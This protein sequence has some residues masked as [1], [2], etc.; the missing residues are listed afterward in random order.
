MPIEICKKR[1]ALLRDAGSLLVTGGAGAGKTTIALAKA[2]TDLDEGTLGQSGKA[3]FLSFARATIARV[4]EQVVKQFPKHRAR[5]EINTY[6]GFAWSILKSH[7]YLL[8][9]RR[10]VALLVPAMARRYLAG[11]SGE[12]R[13]RRLLDLFE[14]EGLVAFDLFMPLA[15]QIFERCPSLAEAYA[16]A[17]PLVV[18]DEFQDTSASEWALIKNLGRHSRMIA[19]GDPKQRIYDFKGADPKRFDDFV[20][21]FHPTVYDFEAENRRSSGT[22]IAAFGGDL[23]SGAFGKAEYQGVAVHRFGGKDGRHPLKEAVL[24]ADERLR[25]VGG[26][27]SL[28]VL[29]PTNALAA[30][31]FD[32]LRSREQGLRSCVADILMAPEGPMLAARLIASL[33]EPFSGTGARAAALLDG[34][35]TF[36]VGRDDEASQ[37]AMKKAQKLNALVAKVQRHGVSALDST[38]TARE[39]AALLQKLS[40]YALTGDPLDDWFTIRKLFDRSA[41][42]E[43]QLAGKDARYM[44]LLHR[45]APIAH[46]LSEAWR[47]NGCYV[48]ATAL[49]DAAHIEDQFVATTRGHHGVNVMTMHKAKGKEFDEVII[50]ENLYHRYV[51]NAQESSLA[52]ARFNLHVA[53]TRARRTVTVFTPR[54]AG[55]PLL[56]A[57]TAPVTSRSSRVAR[58]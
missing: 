49:L 56:P 23:L 35:A 40:E 25:K 46:R 34:L 5:L 54:D 30:G 50:F 22:E 2:A 17:Y 44:R 6:H 39:V 48:G 7:A 45:G 1:E 8:G 12:A 18:V 21:Q 55:S 37:S 42:K 41:C 13:Q 10:G 53:V 9:T 15:T 4:A 28:A 33:M 38:G 29:V 3:L 26:E 16:L 57:H 32:F 27:W 24:A 11:L 52:G 31:V 19:L 14:Q 47:T 51:R 58:R 20:E 36:L 43:L